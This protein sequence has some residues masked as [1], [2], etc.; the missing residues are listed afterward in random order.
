M[1]FLDRHLR[2][3]PIYMIVSKSVRSQKS[4]TRVIDIDP[5]SYHG[6]DNC[7][8]SGAPH[9]WG[10]I[11]F[12]T[13]TRTWIWLMA[14]VMADS[15]SWQKVLLVCSQSY[16]RH[17]ATSQPL[18]S[19]SLDTALYTAKNKR[20]SPLLSQC[21]LCWQT[22]WCTEHG[23]ECWKSVILNLTLIT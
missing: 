12:H 17:E 19:H 9:P 14:S 11:D 23:V 15:Q 21:A 16:F 2:N 5:Y 20:Q 1:C 6:N 18:S 13:H 10:M 4:M 8:Y 22:W 3:T 7:F